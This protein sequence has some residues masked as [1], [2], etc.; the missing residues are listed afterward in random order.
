[1]II[2]ELSIFKYPLIKALNKMKGLNKSRKKFMVQIIGLFLSIK[3]PLN[4]L[5][6]ERFSDLDEQSFRNQFEKTFDFM[7]LNKDLVL[8]NGSGH[9]A[10]ALKFHYFSQKCYFPTCIEPFCHN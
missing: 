1:M 5:Q 9:R 8:E 10:N 7:S 6:L 2:Q 4:F 3:G